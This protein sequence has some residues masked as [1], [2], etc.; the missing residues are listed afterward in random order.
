MRPGKCHTNPLTRH[1]SI[2]RCDL[3]ESDAQ[4]PVTHCDNCRIPGRLALA[5]VSAV[6]VV[7]GFVACAPPDTI[8]DRRAR[9]RGPSSSTWRHLSRDALIKNQSRRSRVISTRSGH[10]RQGAAYVA[11]D[12]AFTR[13]PDRSL[14]DPDA[15]RSEHNV[16]RGSE[17]GI[18]IRMKN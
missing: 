13:L 8:G 4:E 6:R 5:P 10:S 16:E 14:D 2:V 15:A 18:P 7:G 3:A 12:N 1:R 17:L 11:F 9:A